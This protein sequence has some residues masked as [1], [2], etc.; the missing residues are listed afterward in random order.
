MLEI[1]MKVKSHNQI[2]MVSDNVQYC[3]APAGRYLGLNAAVGSDRSYINV[4]EDGFVLSDTGRL[5]GSSKPVIYGIRNLVERLNIPLEEVIKFFSINPNRKYGFL[6]HKG[7]LE[8]GKDADFVI[9]DNEYNVVSTYV[10]GNRVY[11][12]AKDGIIF[13]QAYVDKYKLKND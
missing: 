11:D 7:G 2:M 9:I 8:I 12:K 3:G 5:S 6:D 1:M 13:N 10:L 4:T